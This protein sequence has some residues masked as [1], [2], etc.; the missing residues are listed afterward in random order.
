MDAE[1]IIRECEYEKEDRMGMNL[2]ITKLLKKMKEV[3]GKQP[4]VFCFN[5]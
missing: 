3:D 2:D 1:Q 5:E 4:I